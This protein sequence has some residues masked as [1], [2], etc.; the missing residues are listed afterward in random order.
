MPHR[1][2]FILRQTAHVPRKQRRRLLVLPEVLKKRHVRLKRNIESRL[3][4]AHCIPPFQRR[5][6]K[7]L[8]SGRRVFRHEAS[9]VLQGRLGYE[10]R[11]DAAVGEILGFGFGEEAAGHG[12]TG[13]TFQAGEWHFG[14][15]GN[16]GEGCA[17][18]AE[19][20]REVSEDVELEEPAE[21]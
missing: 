2:A 7:P 11:R 14:G 3:I 4:F 20:G 8:G 1:Q 6:C 10:L 18:A 5:L 19:V 17:R 21:T 12:H 16:G 13:D 9:P 15:F